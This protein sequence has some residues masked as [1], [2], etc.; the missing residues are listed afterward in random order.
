MWL[1]FTLF[2]NF[3]PLRSFQLLLAASAAGNTKE[4]TKKTRNSGEDR[5]EKTSTSKNLTTARTTTV[6]KDDVQSFKLEVPKFKIFKGNSKNPK[7]PVILRIDNKFRYFSVRTKGEEGDRKYFY[8]CMKKNKTG[9]NAKA[10]LLDGVGTGESQ[11]FLSRWIIESIQCFFR[12][13]EVKK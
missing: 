3:N 1:I 2:L 4:I 6:E 13:C 9:C 12:N 11:F 7:N 10:H 5:S 8:M